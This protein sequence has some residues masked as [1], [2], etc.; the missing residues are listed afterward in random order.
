MQGLKAG[1]RTMLRMTADTAIQK[2]DKN[3]LWLYWYFLRVGAFTF[4]SAGMLIVLQMKKDFA[5]KYH[6]ITEDEIWNLY[7]VGRSLPGLMIS[8]VVCI[9]GYNFYGVPGAIAAILGVATVPVLCMMAVVLLYGFF[10]DNFWVAAALSGV[11]CV[12][13]PI[14]FASML[15]NVKTAYKHKICI[16]ITLL[17]L[18]FYLLGWNV[19][20][21]IVLDVVIGLAFGTILKRRVRRKETPQ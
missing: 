13:I 8:D 20:R 1:G 4:G 12:V 7:S 11:R 2:E 14:L 10:R 5:D 3:A 18:F 17:S 15:S 16:L 6:W 19:L 21:I 9:F